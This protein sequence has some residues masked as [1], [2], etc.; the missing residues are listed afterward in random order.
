MTNKSTKVTK[1]YDAESLEHLSI[2]E[3]VRRRPGMWIGNTS[4]KGL[5][6]LIH[7]IVDNSVDEFMAGH[8]EKIEVKISK[9]GWVTVRDFARGI[10]VDTHKKS[11][12]SGLE[13]VLTQVGGGGKYGGEDSGY[14]VSGG[15][16]GAGSSVVNFV[17]KE[18]KAKVMRDGF[19]WH[20]TYKTGV[21]DGQIKKGKKTKETGTEI[22]WL[23][24]EE[25][26]DPGTHYEREVAE[27]RLKEIVYLNPGLTIELTFEDHKPE[28]F[29]AEGGLSDYMKALVHDRSEVSAVHKEPIM[30]SGEVTEELERDGKTTTDT[31]T[32]DIALCWTTA[33]N[34]SWH[35]YTNSINN[36]EGGTH[37]DGA[38]KGLR[39]ALNDAAE[40]LGKFRAK[41]EPFEQVDTREG[42]FWAVSAKVSDPQFEGQTKG[43]LN[44]PEVE[45]RV[46]DFVARELFEWLTSKKNKSQADHIISRV[47]EARDGRLAAR[48]AKRAVTERKGLLGAGSGL[49][50]KLADCTVRDRN[51]TE[52]FIVEG[53]SAGG[54]MKQTR[55]KETQAIMPLKGKIQNAEKAGEKTLDSDAIKDILS[56]IGGSVIDV[57]VPVKKNG[58]TVQRTKLMVD[59]S[60][61]RYGSIIIAVDADVDGGHIATLL[62]T[63]FYRFTPQLIKDGR[64][65]LAQLPLYKVEHKKEGRKYLYNDDELQ[66]LVKKDLVKK[67]ADGSPEITRF[68]GLGEMMPEQLRETALDPKT[69]KLRKVIIED[70]DQAEDITT[71][72]MG[73]RVDRRR[74]YIEENATEIEADI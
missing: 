45:K 59:A 41:D 5:H 21:P 6:H 3:Q 42:L 74:E 72:L 54:G 26:F 71:L 50:S 31:T 52:I 44:N 23:F 30:L 13:L 40:E 19:E 48:K 27:R 2:R 36:P 62:L 29:Y 51:Q 57:K 65:Y 56:A 15:L 4:S 60:E 33:Q 70:D 11:G 28:I 61:P 10:P 46:A 25:V 7:E 22:S 67:R 24:D 47:T 73:N 34:E 32:I 17:S 58:K 12:L 37:Y 55:N 53:D 66:D 9:D 38:R 68:K 63:F 49:P 69:R 39:K 20:Q 14:K 64:V 16:H 43:K 35:A 1:S 8:G 18:M